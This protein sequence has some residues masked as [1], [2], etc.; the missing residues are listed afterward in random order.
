MI[1]RLDELKQY[2]YYF[3]FTINSYGKDIEP[4]VPSKNDEVIM[5]F[6]ALSKKI[7]D[8]KMIWRYDPVLINSQIL[9]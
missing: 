4:N 7:G 6:Q 5:T 1:N 2:S 3:Q 8:Q 9:P